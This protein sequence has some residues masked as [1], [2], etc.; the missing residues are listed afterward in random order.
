VARATGIP[1]RYVSGYLMMPDIEIQ[2]ASHAWAEAHISGLGW[3]GFDAAN[4]KCPDEHY[5]RVAVGLD[6]RDAAPVSGIR[7]GDGNEQ[8]A[9][10]LKVEQ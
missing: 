2:A 5:V 10:N 4:N 1:A 6:Y 7:L 8:L 9:V 3:I